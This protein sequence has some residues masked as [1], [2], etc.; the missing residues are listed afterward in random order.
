MGQVKALIWQLD[1]F[2]IRFQLVYVAELLIRSITHPSASAVSLS[3]STR[4]QQQTT[5]QS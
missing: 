4:L 5:S 1:L 3:L 2:I